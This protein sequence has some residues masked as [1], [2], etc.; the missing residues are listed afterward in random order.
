MSTKTLEMSNIAFDSD[1]EKVKEHITGV[2]HLLDPVVSR[3]AML[4]PLWMFVVTDK[5][6]VFAIGFTVKQDGEVLGRIDTSYMGQRG[7]VIRISN[8]RIGKSRTRSE[9]YRTQDADKAIVMAKKMF[10]KM[11][12]N[13][14][15]DKAKDSAERVVTR[16]AWNKQREIDSHKRIVT[17][18]RSEWAQTIGHALFMKYIAEEAHPLIARDVM[19]AMERLATTELE[20]KTIEEVQK[21]FG[22]DA[23]ALVIKDSGKYLVKIADRVDVYDDNTLPMDMRMKLGMLKLVENEQYVTDMGC[24]VTDEIFVLLVA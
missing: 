8:D 3:L 4:N 1:M 15:I 17:T 12:P 2:Y 9:A 16:G 13:E 7:R 5:M 10:G 19:Q 21:Q 11:N 6:G 18:A 23:T 14:R 22:S 20:M 24:K